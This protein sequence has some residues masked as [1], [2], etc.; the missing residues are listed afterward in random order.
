MQNHD[1]CSIVLSSHILNLHDFLINK[2][3]DM[4]GSMFGTDRQGH[5]L[6]LLWYIAYIYTTVYIDIVHQK[7]NILINYSHI[8]PNP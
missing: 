5:H 8:V 7:M 3:N 6:L 4:F 2:K 1:L